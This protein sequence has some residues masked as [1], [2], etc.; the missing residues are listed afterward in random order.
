MECS[1]NRGFSHYRQ[2][3][4]LISDRQDEGFQSLDDKVQR[5]ILAI[6]QGQH[7][8]DDIKMLLTTHDASTKQHISNEFEKQRVRLAVED[9]RK[10]LLESLYFPEISARQEEVKE[11]HSKTFR[12]I[13][14]ETGEALRPWI[15]F[16]EWL[17][18]GQGTYWLNGKAGSGKS[19]LMNTVHQDEQTAAALSIWSGNL[20]LITPAFFFWKAG[21]EMQK[22]N[23]GLLRAL[24]YQIVSA[25]PSETIS[26]GAVSTLIPH[27]S[28]QLPLWTEKR[29]VT[30]LFQ[31]IAEI[32][33]SFRLCIFIDGLDEFTGDENVLLSLIEQ[34]SQLSNT[35]L[36]LSSRPSLRFEDKLGSSAML[37]LQDLTRSDIKEYTSA[38]LGVVLSQASHAPQES[39]WLSGTVRKIA[40]RAEGVFL[41][42]EL[43]VKNQS[44]GVYN[45]DDSQQLQDRLGSFPTELEDVYSFM[46]Q[47]IDKVYR[48]EVALYLSLAMR[49]PNL[50]L[51]QVALASF[52]GLDELLELYPN[53]PAVDLRELCSL[54]RRRIAATCKDWLEVSVEPKKLSWSHVGFV[55]R[56]AVDF[57]REN[58][59]GKKFLDEFFLTES[60][61]LIMQLKTDLAALVLDDGAHR[62]HLGDLESE[63]ELHDRSQRAQVERILSDMSECE[64]VTGEVFVNYIELLDRIWSSPDRWSSPLPLGNHWRKFWDLGNRY[65]KWRADIDSISNPSDFSVDFLIL[66]A[67]HGLQLYVLRELES[68]PTLQHPSSVLE[69]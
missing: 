1:T 56:T 68:C 51:R 20:S 35:K 39:D 4:H 28:A 52:G 9:N 32:S 62:V 26:L 48:R 31:L 17:R 12:W 19:T 69:I 41:W 30:T 8:F 66:A 3:V 5:L 54:T 33:S 2:R 57:L 29:L 63:S 7:N 42:V 38:K 45:G 61:L 34:L 50:L 49:F 55:H 60:S 16:T 44:E 59:V 13:F 67:T 6:A 46:L 27:A 37:R 14:D 65:L 58:E 22:T 53:Q 36:C 18:E 47:R 25:I 11:A 23:V 15:N 10:R 43:A 24:L 40:E 64:K 21:S